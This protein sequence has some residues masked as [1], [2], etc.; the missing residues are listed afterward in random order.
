MSHA[1]KIHFM[2]V[3]LHSDLILIWDA[4]VFVNQCSLLVKFDDLWDLCTDHQSSPMG[5][6]ENQLFSESDDS[7]TVGSNTTPF[8]G[9]RDHQNNIDMKEKEDKREDRERREII[10]LTS[11]NSRHS[12]SV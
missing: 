11:S 9:S 1:K 4:Y 7:W 6:R 12:L 8:D 5:I 2:S 3:F 10:C